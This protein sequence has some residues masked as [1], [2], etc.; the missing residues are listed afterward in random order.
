MERIMSP[1]ER[2]RRAQEIYY[3]K[4]K[5]NSSLRNI[6]RGKNE[7]KKFSIFK[8]LII[9]ITLCL[10]IYAGIAVIKNKNYIFS[11][12]F[13]NKINQT[14]AYDVNIEKYYNEAINF[15]ENFGKKQETEKNVNEENKT[16]ETQEVIENENSIGGAIE[17]QNE[18][19]QNTENLSQMEIDSIAIKD[20]YNLIKPLEGT[21]TSRFGQ[22]ESSNP[23]VPKNHTGIDIAAAT[24]TP[25]VAALD[26]VVEVSSSEGDYGKHLKIKKDDIELVYAHCSKLLK[27]E[28]DEVKQGETIAEVGATG[29]ATG[30]HLHFEIRKEGRYINP[31]LILN[32]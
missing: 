29:N 21:I 18:E 19:Q 28:G 15:I 23:N 20:T 7:K 32:F 27:N 2:L 9:Q 8:K 25:I 4:N 17:E 10:V 31:D 30:P 12:E 14:L 6:S 5:S 26:G 22:R 16:E 11:E 13:L 24:G 1:D 3:R